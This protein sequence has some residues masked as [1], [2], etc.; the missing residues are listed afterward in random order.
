M[1]NEWTHFKGADKAF[2]VKDDKGAVYAVD[3]QDIAKLVGKKVDV[4][5]TVAE[6]DGKKTIKATK[7]DEVK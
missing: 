3:G 2:C 1:M 6:A 4:T 7:V 5:G